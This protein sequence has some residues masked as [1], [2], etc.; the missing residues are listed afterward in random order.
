MTD[1]Q[2]QVPEKQVEQIKKAYALFMGYESPD[3]ALEFLK[4]AQ[5]HNAKVELDDQLAKLSLRY[6]PMARAVYEQLNAG[7]EPGKVL[8]MLVNVLC[9]AEKRLLDLYNS[10]PKKYTYEPGGIMAKDMPDP[11]QVLMGNIAEHLK[12]QPEQIYPRPDICPSR[13]PGAPP[14]NC[15][16]YAEARAGGPVKNMECRAKENDALAEQMNKPTKGFQDKLNAILKQ[17]D[18]GAKED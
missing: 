9:H 8:A 18:N 10:Y 5:A 7:M 14:C 15:L 13:H 3:I 17:K 11:N 4:L 16:E 1:E 12:Q 6:E 2:K